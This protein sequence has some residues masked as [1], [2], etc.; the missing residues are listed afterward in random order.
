MDRRRPV[1]WR[2][3]GEVVFIVGPAMRWAG[4][5]QV[6]GQNT[7]VMAMRRCDGYD[8][9]SRRRERQYD[10]ASRSIRAIAISLAASAGG[11]ARKRS[12]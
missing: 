10:A 1:G 8:A 6:P 12:P 2:L 3:P 11:K 4:P 9:E 5:Q 7:G